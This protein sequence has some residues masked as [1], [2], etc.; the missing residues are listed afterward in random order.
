TA[1]RNGPLLGKSVVTTSTLPCWPL[2][3][4]VTYTPDFGEDGVIMRASAK[5][6]VSIGLQFPPAALSVPCN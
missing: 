2:F 5:S 3:S 6:C 4:L 1:H